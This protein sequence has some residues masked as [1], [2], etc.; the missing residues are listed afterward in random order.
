MGGGV[1][2]QMEAWIKPC[3]LDENVDI[4]LLTFDEL[5]IILQFVRGDDEEGAV[6]FQ[7]S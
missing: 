5:T 7:S 6:H 3:I 1:E 2:A 4:N